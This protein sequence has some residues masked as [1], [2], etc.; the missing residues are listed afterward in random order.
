MKVSK[1]NKIVGKR[2]IWQN[3][4]GCILLIKVILVSRLRKMRM[5]RIR[6]KRPYLSYQEALLARSKGCVWCMVCI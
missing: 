2:K 4:K 1:R 6:K 5:V 3:E